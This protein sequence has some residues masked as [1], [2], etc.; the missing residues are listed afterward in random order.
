MPSAAFQQDDEITGSAFDARLAKRLVAYAK[1]YGL[2]AAGS[3]SILL[4][5]GLLQLAGPLLTR[6]V[7]DV[8]V[9]AA[10]GAM[11]VRDALL[12]V[13][14]LA[15]QFVAGYGETVLTAIIG[16]RVMRDMREE[17]FAHVQRLSIPFFDRNP[18][19][20]LVTRL[21]QDIESLNE[22]FTAGVVAG[23]GDL[24]TLV[25]IGVLMLV[26]D[27]RLALAAFGVV[28]FIVAVSHV[29]QQRVRVAYRDIRG[30]LARIN[31]FL[32]ERLS[33]MRVVQV[34]GREADER[35]RF[36]AL[37]AD[38]FIRITTAINDI[39]ENDFRMVGWNL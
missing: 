17:L 19:G 30:K 31:A 14:V 4:V 8:A 22:L 18:V 1:P 11:V 13:G 33:G 20:R 39:F 26:I 3:L 10:D 6:H 24:F 5:D 2:L 15:A 29:F 35:A 25:A 16:Q 23:F 12:F 27:W 21:T 36:A 37:N 9:P 34:F 38:H 32:Q 7:I 28:P